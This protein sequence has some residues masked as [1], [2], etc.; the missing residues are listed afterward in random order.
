MVKQT[1]VLWVGTMSL[2]E[3]NFVYVD[4]S[5]VCFSGVFLF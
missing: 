2:S 3:V 1:L 5:V 4:D